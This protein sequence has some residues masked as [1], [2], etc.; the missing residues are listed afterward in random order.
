[1][2]ESMS[3]ATLTSMQ[4]AL[5]EI[6]DLP[7]TPDVREYLLTDR[8]QLANIPDS[9][10]CDEQ[11]LLAEEG[12]TLSMALYIDSLV[13]QRLAGRDPLAALT[14][15]N[16]ADYLTVAEG[17]S[18]F[19]Y[20]AWSSGFDK[21][22]TLLELELQAEVDKYVLA[23][24]LLSAQNGRFP[25]ELHRALFDRTRVDPVAAAGREG[26]YRT[27]SRYAARFCRRMAAL[28]ERR[29]RGPMHE[30]LAELRRFYRLGSLR[31]LAHIERFA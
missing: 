28:L 11:L 25:R 27:A 5:A 17:V 8:A 14:H 2:N 30:A 6:Y 1:M 31:K 23:A 7:A 16:L 21:P 3:D 22:V 24:W 26:L 15:E 20:V 4:E 29:R 12:D 9:R 18:H 13:L 10:P 19:V